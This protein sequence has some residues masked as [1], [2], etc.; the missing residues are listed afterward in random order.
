MQSTEGCRGLQLN[1]ITR[2]TH[3]F[4]F[5]LLKEN[6]QDKLEQCSKM[7][8]FSNTYF[9]S[10]TQQLAQTVQKLEE[11]VDTLEGDIEILRGDIKKNYDAHVKNVCSNKNNLV[12]EVLSKFPTRAM[13]AC[14]FFKTETLYGSP[15]SGA[16]D[17]S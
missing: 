14:L 10:K 5:F 15:N 3:S 7:S 4:L 2:V 1:Q 6:V 9:A 17:T 16:Q 13:F 8:E 12:L 11:Q